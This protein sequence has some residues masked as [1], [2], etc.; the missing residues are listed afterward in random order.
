MLQRFPSKSQHQHNNQHPPLLWPTP[1]F[2][3]PQEGAG[4]SSSASSDFFRARY[5]RQNVGKGGGALA[6]GWDVAPEGSQ[7]GGGGGGAGAREVLTP[8]E[9]SLLKTLGGSVAG[10][11]GAGARGG[12]AGAAGLDRLMRVMINAPDVSLLLRR[13]EERRRGVDLFPVFFFVV[14]VFSPC[15]SPPPL[16]LSPPSVRPFNSFLARF[17]TAVKPCEGSPA[18]F[19]RS[20]L[21]PPPQSDNVS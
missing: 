2:L 15:R 14:L 7:G 6:P 9:N 21:P 12:V 4:G 20:P 1:P 8:A 5:K 10:G 3:Q 16:S 13:G 11:G 19:T 17:F 18:S